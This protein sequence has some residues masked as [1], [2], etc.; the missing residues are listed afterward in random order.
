MNV[1]DKTG[2]E[3]KRRRVETK[4]EGG[5]RHSRISHPGTLR[6]LQNPVFE[7]NNLFVLQSTNY[8]TA[9]MLEQPL[10]LRGS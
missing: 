8:I 3:K 4:S 1:S 7:K 2:K 6:A 5:E 10:R 9:C